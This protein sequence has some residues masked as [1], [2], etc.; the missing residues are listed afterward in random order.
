[1]TGG[2]NNCD[3]GEDLVAYLYKEASPQGARDFEEHLKACQ[4]CREELESLGNL[5]RSL[6]EWQIE[7]VPRIEVSIQRQPVEI[8]KELIS[9]LPAWIKVGGLAAASAIVVFLSLALSGTRIDWREGNVKLGISERGEPR[10][11]R[12]LDAS[13][14]LQLTRAEIDTMIAER[15]K[16][17]QMEQAHSVEEMKSQVTSLSQQLARTTEAQAK[18]VQSLDTVRKEQRILMARSQSTLG[19]WLFAS[20]GASDQ[21]EGNDRKN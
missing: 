6:K 11:A 17:V 3:R 7:A 8:L 14:S 4:G 15:V 21:D 16:A 19:E 2:M 1:M 13:S 12:I 10:E 18:L 20:N 5:R 9:S